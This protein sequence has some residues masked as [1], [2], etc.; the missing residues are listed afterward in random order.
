[1][2]RCKQL[3]RAG[4]EHPS[5]LVNDTWY[6]VNLNTGAPWRID[7]TSLPGDQPSPITGIPV[8][9]SQFTLAGLTNYTTYKI[10]LAT[11]PPCLSDTVIVFPTDL[12]LVAGNRKFIPFR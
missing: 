1:M 12:F 2:Q 6:T 8:D 10:T 9:N 7:Y 5:L 4:L 11:D 3:S